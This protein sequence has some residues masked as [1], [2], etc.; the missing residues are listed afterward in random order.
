MNSAMRVNEDI[1][2]F[3]ARR[4]SIFL[5]NSIEYL[6][7]LGQLS[8]PRM[9]IKER[10]NIICIFNRFLATPTFNILVEERLHGVV[11]PARS[12]C[13]HAQSIGMSRWFRI[14]SKPVVQYL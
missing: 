4:H 13:T 3:Y 8:A 7:N 6:N 10:S 5:L 11:L 1:P 2:A 9:Y 14:E 12:K